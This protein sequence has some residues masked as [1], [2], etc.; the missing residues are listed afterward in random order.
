MWLLSFVFTAL[1]TPIAKLIADLHTFKALALHRPP[2]LDGKARVCFFNIFFLFNHFVFFFYS[3]SFKTSCRM[4]IWIVPSDR[5]AFAMF[6]IPKSW[7]GDWL[8]PLHAPQKRI[9]SYLLTVKHH[10][11]STGILNLT[12]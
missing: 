5:A 2:A 1:R 11:H 6:C 12:S 3:F 9:N 10:C 4:N 7:K 8:P